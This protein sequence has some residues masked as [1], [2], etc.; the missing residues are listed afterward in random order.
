MKALGL[1][2]EQYLA[3]AEAQAQQHIAMTMRDWIAKLDA[4]VT[5]NGRELLTH[6]GKITHELAKEISAVQLDKLK[7]RLREQ[8]KE[9]SLDELENDLKAIEQPKR[10]PKNGAEEE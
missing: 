10:P 5:L 3:F 4:I 2:V 1:L 7:D 6:A 9:A 8:E